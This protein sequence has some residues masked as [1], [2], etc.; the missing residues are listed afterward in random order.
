M[1]GG[2]K[3]EI[4]LLQLLD[5]RF[6]RFGYDAAMPKRRQKPVAEIVVFF[7]ARMYVSD[8]D[9][10]SFQ[11]DR[12]TVTARLPV[13]LKEPLFQDRTRLFR[14]FRGIPRQIRIHR[15]IAEYAERG[16]EVVFRKS[17]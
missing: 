9:I 15:E 3:A 2:D 6:S 16:A 13:Y 1:R 11:T 7:R 12:V 10:V 17:S 5:E 8:R 14:I 4:V